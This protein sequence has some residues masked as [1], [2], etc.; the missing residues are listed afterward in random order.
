MQGPRHDEDDHLP[1]LAGP[2]AWRKL[3]ALATGT[4]LF[5][6][7]TNQCPAPSRPMAVQGVDEQ[8]A[9]YFFSAAASDKNRELAAD[10][11]VQRYFAR[12]GASEY[13]SIYGR[14]TVS[15][16]RAKMAAYWQPFLKTWFR[17]GPNDP[18]LTLVWVQPAAAH[19]CPP[20]HRRMVA[21]LK[22]AASLVA[23]KALDGGAA[24]QLIL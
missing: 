12:E 10:P 8:G 24:G 23:G 4:C 5:T 17:G 7:A 18:D 16:D 21:L 13:L 1:S 6:T 11:A 20:R 2:E 19:Y 3:R 14:A 22:I 9:L 15:R